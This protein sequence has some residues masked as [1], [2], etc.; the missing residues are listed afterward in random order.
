MVVYLI[1]KSHYTK[2]MR[3]VFSIFPCKK[4]QFI[5]EILLKTGMIYE[6]QLLSALKEQKTTRMRFGEILLKNGWISERELAQGLSEQFNIP[7]SD[8]SGYEPQKSA[9]LTV[10]QSMAE[11]LQIL[12]LELKPGG[13]LKVATAE[14]IDVLT[15]DELHLFTGLDIDL[16]LATG[17]D[18]QSYTPSFY[19]SLETKPIDENSTAKN[20]LI[21][22]ILLNARLISEKQIQSVLKEQKHTHMRFGEILLK[23]GWLSEKDLAEGLSSQLGIPVYS[24][25]DFPPEKSALEKVPENIALRLQALPL[26]IQDN[27]S[28]LV[29]VSEP[30]DVLA[31]D[32]LCHITGMQLEV[33]IALPSELR[34][35]IPSLY[36]DFYNSSHDLIYCYKKTLLGQ[37]LL[38]AGLITEE[39]LTEVLDLQKS[40]HKRLGD[41]LLENRFLNER[42]LTEGLSRQMKLPTVLLSDFKPQPQLLNLIPQ[43][44]AES[45]QVLPLSEDEHGR[46]IMGI[47]EP[48]NIET[49]DELSQLVGKDLVFRLARPSSLKNEIPSFYARIRESREVK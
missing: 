21:G 3:G 41:I 12:P 29:A 2:L 46:I 20:A 47:A 27:D 25:K 22:G 48:L 30:M 42:E 44:I 5:G 40:N 32:E 13:V 33:R 9:L 31:I 28:L 26:R 16:V 19:D 1:I 10:P 34:R 39:E 43:A 37:V 23:N 14:P 35:E 7:L 18:I 11:K 17:T 45:F 49:Q 15:K 36:N 4:H 6:N 38:N 8:L 24:T